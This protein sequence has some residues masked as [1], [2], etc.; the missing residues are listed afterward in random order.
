LANPN[1]AFPDINYGTTSAGK[2]KNLGDTLKFTPDSETGT[3]KRGA[4]TF[5][6]AQWHIHVPSEH[7]V[8]GQDFAAEVHCELLVKREKKV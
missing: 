8:N 5:K 1:K 7:R 6:L 2:L 3:F 4:N